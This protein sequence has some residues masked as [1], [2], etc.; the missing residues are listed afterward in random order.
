MFV[1]KTDNV[2]KMPI[3]TDDNLEDFS[4]NSSSALNKVIVSSP[5]KELN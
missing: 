4:D 5:T 3:V 1:L 2:I